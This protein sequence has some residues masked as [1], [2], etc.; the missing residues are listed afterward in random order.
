MKIP[1][2]REIQQIAINRFSDIGF[3]ETYYKTYFFLVNGTT[4]ASGN[5]FR[6]K[7]DLLK[8]V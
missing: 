4:L 6:F 7:H 5:P 3:K 1:I 2:K 8:I